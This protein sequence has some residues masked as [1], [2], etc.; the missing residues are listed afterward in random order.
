KV[1]ALRALGHR[2]LTWDCRLLK[3]EAMMS[4]KALQLTCQQRGEFGFL[5]S[6]RLYCRQSR[7][8]VPAG[9]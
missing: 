6:Q 1:C 9:N 8:V 4:I 2:H 7:K 3:A 5:F